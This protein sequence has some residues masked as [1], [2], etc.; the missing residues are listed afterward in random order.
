MFLTGVF[1]ICEILISSKPK[2]SDNAFYVSVSLPA[3]MPLAGLP[4]W[5]GQ[6]KFMKLFGKWDGEGDF[7]DER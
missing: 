5:L 1:R 3:R 6:D 4:A 7:F 2:R